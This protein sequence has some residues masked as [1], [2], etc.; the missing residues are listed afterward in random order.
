MKAVI[1]RFLMVAALAMAM[2]LQAQAAETQSLHDL[3]EAF[4]SAYKG[5]RK[6]TDAEKALPLVR[7]A[8]EASLQSISILPPML[9]K[10]P[11]GPAKVKAAATYRNMMAE[12]YLTLTRI[13]LAYIT[14][15]LEAVAEHV[16][17]IR[18]ARRVGHEQFME[19]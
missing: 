18:N 5:F 7:D 9:V 10:M 3:M 1:S 8:Q 17:E 11:D 14:D 15:D 4:D 6:E 12:V 19:E 13:E 16:A 2:P